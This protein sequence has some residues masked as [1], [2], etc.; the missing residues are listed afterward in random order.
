MKTKSRV[1]VINMALII[2]F[3]AAAGSAVSL[4]RAEIL[5]GCAQRSANA[6]KIQE[7]EK[8]FEET[9]KTDPFNSQYFGAFAEFLLQRNVNGGRKP[10]LDRI[11]RSDTL[12][13]RA[14]NLNPRCAE[15]ALAIGQIQLRFF[16]ETGNYENKKSAFYYFRKALQEDPN[17]FNVSYAVGYAGISSWQ[18]LDDEEKDLI[19]N[20]LSYSL[21]LQPRYSRYIYP[22]IWKKTNDFH[23]LLAIVNDNR[24]ARKRLRSFVL[25][26]DLWHLG[27]DQKEIVDLFR[28][29]EMSERS[30]ELS[31]PEFGYINFLKEK[32]TREQGAGKISLDIPRDVW[33]GKSSD[34]KNNISDGYLCWNGTVYAILNMKPGTVRISIQ[35]KKRQV[36]NIDDAKNPKY[37]PH[38]VV[39]LDGLE[40]G[41]TFVISD[42]WGCYDFPARTNGGPKVLSVTLTNDI[43]DPQKGEDRNLYVGDVRISYE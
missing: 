13:G 30:Q 7:A 17:G 28:E 40:I 43:Y 21:K 1:I 33:R 19:L 2:S 20:R 25:D 41:E 3:I 27:A 23:A 38:M 31:Q 16:L 32:F 6:A 18:A 11:K 29:V 24:K 35:A 5:F 39:R 10:N 36:I 26:N 8:T 4:F 34:G 42:E 12:Y 9:I 22:Y 15:Y 14:L 37:Y